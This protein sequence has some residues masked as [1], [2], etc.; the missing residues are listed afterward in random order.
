MSALD[1]II[2]LTN[3]VYFELVLYISN[4]IALLIHNVALH[5][6]TANSKVTEVFRKRSKCYNEMC[7]TILKMI[8]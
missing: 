1:I 8:L 6:C 3:D 4:Y 7:V 5:R 2:V